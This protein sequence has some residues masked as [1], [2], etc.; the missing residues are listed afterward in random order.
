MYK[1][2]SKKLQFFKLKPQDYENKTAF[3]SH[4]PAVNPQRLNE[5]ENF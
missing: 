2:R 4:S 1:N 5:E 3:V